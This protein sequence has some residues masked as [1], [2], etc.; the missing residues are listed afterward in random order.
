[1]WPG[2]VESFCCSV[3]QQPAR[4]SPLNIPQLW[5]FTTEVFTEVIP[6]IAAHLSNRVIRGN[7]Y[8]K[9]HLTNVSFT[10]PL[11][12]KSRTKISELRPCESIIQE[13]E[14]ATTLCSTADWFK[15][16]KCTT[17]CP[18][19]HL[20]SAIPILI[21]PCVI[22]NAIYGILQFNI[23]AQSA[24]KSLVDL[25]RALRTLSDTFKISCCWSKHI[26]NFVTLLQA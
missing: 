10:I 19:L 17:D 3:N 9:S 12:P 2:V 25:A 13:I 5:Y 18:G 8:V 26:A 20:D 24:R 6:S 16:C 22:K 21:L 1:M 14:R 11:C 23:L 4:G 7:N 15:I